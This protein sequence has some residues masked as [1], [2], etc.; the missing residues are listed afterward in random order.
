MDDKQPRLYGV[1]S[2]NGNDGV[3]HMFADYYVTTNDP[4]RLAKLAMV[5]QFKEAYQAKALEECT[6][7]GEAEYTVQAVIYEPL[8]AEPAE[9]GESYCDANGCAYLIDV[10]PEGEPR[11]GVMQYASLEEAFDAATLAKIID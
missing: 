5:T 7:D 9:E 11:E 6:V 1:S 8:D 3:S 10:F 4:W 2:G